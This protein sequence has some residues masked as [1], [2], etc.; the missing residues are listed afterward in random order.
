MIEKFNKILFGD[1][2]CI[3]VILAV[4]FIKNKHLLLIAIRQEKETIFSNNS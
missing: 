4:N 2:K 3:S 1:Y